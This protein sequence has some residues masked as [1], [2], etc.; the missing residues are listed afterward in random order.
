MYARDIVLM[1]FKRDVNTMCLKNA[2]LI[3]ICLGLE[4]TYLLPI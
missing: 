2:I 1:E 3:K 4:S